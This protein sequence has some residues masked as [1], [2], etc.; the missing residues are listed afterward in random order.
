MLKASDSLTA[1]R[2]LRMSA[3][4]HNL[5]SALLR[6]IGCGAASGMRPHALP[7]KIS[8]EMKDRPRTTPPLSAAIDRRQHTPREAVAD[9]FPVRVGRRPER[10]PD[11]SEGHESGQ[12][13]G[14]VLEILCK[15]PVS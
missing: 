2:F 4:A 5:P 11:T 12:G 10:K 3:G 14:R 9:R 13:F 6:S 1:R 8:R 15:T 7:A